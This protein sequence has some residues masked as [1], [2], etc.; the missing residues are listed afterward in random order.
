M[1]WFNFSYAYQESE[2]KIGDLLPPNKFAER[3]FTRLTWAA[4][5]REFVNI[6][7]FSKSCE[8]GL[9]LLPLFY[10]LS[11]TSRAFLN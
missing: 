1:F 7:I 10:K 11:P 4:E 5:R 2:P 6:S 8:K 9:F 3:Q